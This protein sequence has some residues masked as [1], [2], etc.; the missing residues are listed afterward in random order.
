MPKLCNSTLPIRREK[1]R[2]KAQASPLAGEG[3][4]V[5]HQDYHPR[6]RNRAEMDH[7]DAVAALGC[8]I[9]GG[10]AEIHHL[11]HDPATGQHIA[12]RNH[13]LVIPLCPNHHRL[14]GWGVAYHA[15]SQHWE[16]LYGKEIHIWTMVQVTLGL[17][18]EL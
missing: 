2:R 4:A 17:E 16:T 12:R 7:H 6:R 11:K 10:P 13:R 15:G 1:P 3:A 5:L 9:C 8:V 18:V 14:G